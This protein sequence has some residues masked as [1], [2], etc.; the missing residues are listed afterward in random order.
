MGTKKGRFVSKSGDT[1]EVR[2]SGNS[3]IGGDIILGVPPVTISMAAGEHKFCGFKGTTAVVNILTD[4]PLID[5]YAQSVTDVQL[6]VENITK[7]SIEFD[8]YVTPFAFDQPFTGKLDSVTVNAVDLISV[9]KDAKYENIGTEHGTDRSALTI[10]QEICKR[11]GVNTLYLHLNFND[12]NDMMKN[13]SPLDVMV[14]QAGFLQD[15]VSDADALS[16]ICKF[17]GYTGHVIGRSLYLY[18]EY[19]LADWYDVNIYALYSSGWTKVSHSFNDKYSVYRP[20]SLASIH[21][22]ISVS[23]ERAYDG[24]QIEPEGSEVSILLPDVC[25]LEN[26]ERSGA[27]TPTTTVDGVEYRKIARE[28][29]YLTTG[30][31]TKNGLEPFKG[32][33]YLDSSPPNAIDKT[34]DDWTVGSVLVELESNEKKVDGN[35]L[36]GNSFN[37]SCYLWLRDGLF[38]PS[39]ARTFEHKE[40]TRYSHTRG[41]IVLKAKASITL[42]IDDENPILP[43]GQKKDYLINAPI[44]VRVGEKYINAVGQ[45]LEGDYYY[46]IA[47]VEDSNG[48]GCQFYN[49]DI[50]PT[51]NQFHES[52]G[53]ELIF[54]ELPDG[55]V[56]LDFWGNPNAYAQTYNWMFTSLSIEAVGTPIE[57]FVHNFQALGEQ[58]SVTSM[59]TSR[60]SNARPAVVTSESYAA[61]YHGG[62]R[63]K[64]DDYG[65]LQWQLVGRYGQPHAAYKMTVDGNINP[66]A[67]VI[68]NDKTYT[69]EAYDRDIYNDTTTITID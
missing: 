9:R 35:V 1:Y 12:T 50:V 49:G 46:L 6:T 26:S 18:D 36:T 55:Q 29:K 33:A 51:W 59:L 14:A 62:G 47:Q 21:N 38:Q 19:L 15:E 13:A 61:L 57:P 64:V 31:S 65:V 68:F 58:L 48:I 56:Y 34:E 11:A 54:D 53:F 42:Q 8:G 66:Y 52:V 3:V 37:T 39:S 41:K 2:L 22:G 63:Y 32:K 10:V 20:Q 67:G 17:F 24:I 27:Y 45:T 16:A 43:L 69:V 23:V 40:N 30:K 44:R 7:G 60:G 5:L 25:D 28:S 4:V